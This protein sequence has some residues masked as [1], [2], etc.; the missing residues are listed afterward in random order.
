MTQDWHA[1]SAKLPWPAEQLGCD[2]SF[3]RPF[4]RHSF[5]QKPVVMRSTII[6]PGLFPRHCSRLVTLVAALCA[7]VSACWASPVLMISIDG[8]KPEY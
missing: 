4:F 3:R 8:L 6:M 1:G 7:A 2:P 5:T